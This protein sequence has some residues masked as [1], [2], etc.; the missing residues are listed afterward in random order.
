VAIFQIELAKNDWN[1]RTLGV[2]KKIYDLVILG[3]DLPAL[4]LAHDAGKSGLKT[5]VVS[6]NET[7]GGSF[8]PAT[9]PQGALH[10]DFGYWPASDSFLST[11]EWIEN[12][13]GIK[14]RSETAPRPCVTFQKGSAQ[15]FVG[16]GEKAPASIDLLRSYLDYDNLDLLAPLSS[17]VKPLVQAG[18]FETKLNFI[19]EQFQF[20]NSSVV[21]A[22]SYDGT[23]IQGDRWVL[24]DSLKNFFHLL[25]SEHY[26]AREQAKL[27]KTKL[28]TQVSLDILHSKAITNEHGMHLLMGT[29]DDAIPC[30]GGF[31]T[32]NE[33]GLQA[34]HWHCYVDPD[35]EDEEATAHA[36]RE[37][38]RQMKRVYPEIFDKNIFEKISVEADALGFWPAKTDA[39]GRW[40][41]L[42]NLWVLDSESQN[43]PGIF[44]KLRQAYSVAL[45]LGKNSSQNAPLISDSELGL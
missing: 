32:P 24:C 3:S 4:L 43:Q 26:K 34:S 16:F 28:W 11:L 35:S 27:H 12:S 22:S 36:L 9:S 19:V 8:A 29:T 21:S 13:I 1:L 25:P 37:M 38:K 44:S 18:T 31:E 41:G 10:R 42:E 2:S 17:L 45:S 5:L 14:L 23:T 20:Q 7:L 6:R 15:T 39:S 33:Q 40:I 30:L